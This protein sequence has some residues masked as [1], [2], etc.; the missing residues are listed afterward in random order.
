MND[1]IDTWL[2]AYLDGELGSSQAQQVD[3][4]LA[5]CQRCQAIFEQRV[6]LSA[7]LQQV[8]AATGL[9]PQE[10][11]AAEVKLSIRS[12]RASH[13]AQKWLYRAWQFAPVALLLAWAFLYTVS[14]LSNLLLI[15]PGGVQTVQ[16]QVSPLVSAL[17][18]PWLAEFEPAGPQVDGLGLLLGSF[19]ILDW[20]WLTSL[21][22][23]AAIGLLYLGWLATWLAR[24]RLESP[25][26][27]EQIHV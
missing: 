2:D 13:Q 9:K 22:A 5:E 17:K 20:N 7:F 27:A 24:A 1:H 3:K 8:P 26:P 11:F 25:S 10:Q 19:D 16:Q 6:N 15:L 23:L 4:H 21:I 14:I 18:L 12:Q